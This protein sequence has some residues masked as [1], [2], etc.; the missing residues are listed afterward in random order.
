MKAGKEYEMFVFEKFKDFFNGFELTLND[1]IIGNQSDIKREIDISI[2]G[3]INDVDLLYLVQCKDHNKP[4]DIKIIG[5]FSSVIRDVG[6][7]K[8]FLVC[9]SGFA[10]TIHQY[11]NNLGI[12]LVTVEDINSDKWKVEIQIPIIYIWKKFEILYTGSITVNNELAEKNKSDL[13]I[14]KND[15][16]EISFDFGNNSLQLID[17]LNWI[18]EKDKINVEQTKSIIL[19]DPKLL[20]KF[21]NIWVPV[22]INVSFTTESIYYFKYVCPYE[23]AQLTNHKTKKII[24]LKAKIKISE[25]EFDESYVKI[26]ENNIPVSSPI[27]IEIEENLHP[28]NQ[29]KFDFSGFEFKKM[30]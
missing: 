3:K 13:Q 11:A 28:I 4:A 8:G 14:T 29:L 17:Y 7:S 18:I 23:Y 25:F 27:N 24:P 2:K 9:T 20:L 5:E 22:E 1:R 16:E 26:D 21:A 30:D 19:S 6:A 12:E 15:F 10:K